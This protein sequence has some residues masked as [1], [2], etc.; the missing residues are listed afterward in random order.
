VG[1]VVHSGASVA[2]NIDVLYFML[3]WDRCGFHKSSLGQVT[4]KL[5]FCIRWDMRVTYCIP[6]RLG[7][8]MSMHYFSCSCGMVQIPQ[9]AHPVTLRGTRVLNSMGSA[10]HVVHSMSTHY[11]SWSSGTGMDSKKRVPGHITPNLCFCILWD[12]RVM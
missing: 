2:C 8:E 10:G 9:K 11:F 5:C 4:L 12:L 1:H 6:L 3:G 7:H